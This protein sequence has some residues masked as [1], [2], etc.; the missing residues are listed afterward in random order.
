[1]YRF[2]RCFVVDV[3]GGGGGGSIGR[4]SVVPTETNIDLYFIILCFFVL[5]CKTVHRMRTVLLWC[6]IRL[7]FRHGTAL[8]FLSSSS[9]VIRNFSI[10]FKMKNTTR[11]YHC[12]LGY[13]R[14]Y[15]GMCA[16]FY[17]FYFYYLLCLNESTKECYIFKYIP[18]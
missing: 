1:M 17:S 12:C 9:R 11:Y 6:A 5:N 13:A 3:R 14:L 7:V 2:I 18:E 10:E 8:L 15:C 4:S 16:F